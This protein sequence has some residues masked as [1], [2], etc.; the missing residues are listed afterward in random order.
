MKIT[1]P[2]IPILGS[3][4]TGPSVRMSAIFACKRLVV[5]YST[6]V[7]FIISEHSGLV[8][9]I[10]SDMFIHEIK[11]IEQR[12]MVFYVLVKSLLLMEAGNSWMVE[13]GIPREK[14]WPSTILALGSA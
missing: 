7:L 4:W 9:D 10:D 1:V 13:T 6:L 12:V 2:V 14:H 5:F 3:T 8:T 11:N